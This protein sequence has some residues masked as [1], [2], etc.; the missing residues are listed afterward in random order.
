[1]HVLLAVLR[2][3]YTA[4]LAPQPQAKHSIAELITLAGNTAGT[5]VTEDAVRTALAALGRADRVYREQVNRP[6]HGL[7]RVYWLS[8]AGIRYAAATLQKTKQLTTKLRPEVS[9]GGRDRSAE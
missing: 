3:L 5:P 8:P 9:A 7:V 4:A 1:M 2:V 6:G